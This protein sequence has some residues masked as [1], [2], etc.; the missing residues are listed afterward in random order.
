MITGLFTECGSQSE[1]T[2]PDVL[3]ELPEPDENAAA[4]KNG[5]MD[6]S[7][8]P[9]ILSDLAYDGNNTYGYRIY[10]KEQDNF[11]PF[12]VLTSDYHGN[13]LL[14]REYLLD[15]CQIYNT[16][17]DYASYYNGS[18]IDN[19]LNQEYYELLSPELKTVIEMTEVEITTKNAIDTHKQETENISRY[20]FLLS[21][22][23]VNTSIGRSAV[24]EGDCLTY[25][26]QQQNLIASF[27][28]LTASSW[29]LRTPALRG[30]STIFGVSDNGVVGMG[31]INT[32]AGLS[33]NAV[34]PVF[35]IA[36]TT[37]VEVSGN[38][39]DGENVV[40][41]CNNESY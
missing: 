39:I 37:P 1:S 3:G 2:S 26:S 29:M 40:I 22:N 32:I 12:L 27:D 35:C 6:M 33:E 30:S 16:T 20:V 23:E 4:E 28:T 10:L 19:F 34:R 7:Q 9:T 21:A 24:P 5:K 11:I 17:G 38:V 25:F 31:G 36:G 15:T 41:L 14:M 8:Q 18:Y 13:C